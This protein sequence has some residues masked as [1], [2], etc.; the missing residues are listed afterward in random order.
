MNE[1]MQHHGRR[2]RGAPAGARPGGVAARLRRPM[3]IATLAAAALV[4]GGWVAVVGANAAAGSGAGTDTNPYSMPTPSH[5]PESVDPSATARIRARIAEVRGL[6]RQAIQQR[7]FSQV[8]GLEIEL[9]GLK[10]QLA[11]ADVRPAA[12]LMGSAAGAGTITPP[13]SSG[14]VFSDARDTAFELGLTA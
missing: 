13:V 11:G 5:A 8:Q 14:G 4:G 10:R 6:E 1:H 7:D 2:R 9:A 12:A 3:T